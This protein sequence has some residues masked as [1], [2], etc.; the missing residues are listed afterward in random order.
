MQTSIRVGII[1]SGFGAKMHAPVMMHHPNYEVKAIASVYRGNTEE[2]HNSTGITNV[3]KNWREMLEREELDLISIVSNPSLH[4]EMVLAGYAQG[5]HILCEKPMAM[6]TSQA[7]E[8]IQARDLAHRKGWINHEFRFIPARLKVKEI[9]QSG[10]L[11]SIIHINYKNYALSNR[12]LRKFGWLGQKEMGGGMLGAIGSHMF[13]ALLWWKGTEITS[14]TGQLSTHNPT[15]TNQI[16]EVEHRTADDAFQVIGSFADGTTLTTELFY[17]GKHIPYRWRLEIFGSNGT[18][19]MTDDMKVELGLGEMSMQEVPLSPLPS[20]P[21]TLPE[22]AHYF[23]PFFTT[24][25]DH[26]YNEITHQKTSGAL[27]TFEDGLRV[28]Q[29]LD[30]VRLSAEEGRRIELDLSK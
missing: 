15:W 16:G 11:G 30:A 20:A 4:H 14:L 22:T 28:Q 29:V 3:Y 24:Y 13:D 8:M 10:Q 27:P 7:L 21:E 17:A 1:G 18:L 2:I 6:N 26:V 9:L 19:I 23:Y 25:L 5:A 12:Y